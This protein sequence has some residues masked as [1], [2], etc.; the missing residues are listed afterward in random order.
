[1]TAECNLH[2]LLLTYAAVRRCFVD[3][4]HGCMLL[5]NVNRQLLQLIVLQLQHLQLG[6]T[7]QCPWLK[8]CQVIA[9]QP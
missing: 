2:I 8:V 7:S 1:M 9:L 5:T 6:K 3:F 4:S